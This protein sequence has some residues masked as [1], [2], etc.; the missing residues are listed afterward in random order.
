MIKIRRGV[1]ETNSSSTHSLTMMMKEDYLR[2]KD[3]NYMYTEREGCLCPINPELT[4]IEGVV[5][6]PEE[7]CAF[8]MN[9]KYFVKHNEALGITEA[10][11]PET[12]A[13]YEPYEYGFDT[14]NDESDYLDS[15]YDEFTT[16]NGETVVAFGE[17]GY[18]G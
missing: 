16:P 1:F 13:Q 4:P 11:T 8:L 7:V 10:P 5:Y 14:I 17:Y 6:T 12:L 15:Y 3:G 9:D 2:W 18:N